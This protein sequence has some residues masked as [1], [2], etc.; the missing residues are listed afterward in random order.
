MSQIYKAQ[1]T[2]PPPPEVPLEFDTQVN[3]PA[4]PALNILI[5]DG[6]A[7]SEDDANGIRSDGSSG[8][9]TLTIQLTNRISGSA[10]AVGAVNADIATFSLGAT[11]S[12]FRFTF[13]VT[14]L[15]TAGAATGDG[16]GYTIDGTARTDGATAAIISVPDIDSDEDTSLSAAQMSLI[17]SGNDVIV[18]ALGV[19]GN[20]ISYNTV[21]TYVKVS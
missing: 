10:S 1:G 19:A 6:G 2:T 21:G 14:G 16:V 15:A 5:V 7:T 3:S 20:T 13:L 11:P 17:A 4:I 12:A 8:G 18:R 9:N